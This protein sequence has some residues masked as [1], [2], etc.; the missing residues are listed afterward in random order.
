MVERHERISERKI[1]NIFM[2]GHTVELKERFILHDFNTI[3]DAVPFIKEIETLG[4]SHYGQK[5]RYGNLRCN[6]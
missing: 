5:I 4:L 3:E 2:S 1:Y 6:H